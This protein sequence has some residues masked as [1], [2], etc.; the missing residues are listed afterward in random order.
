MTALVGTRDLVRFVLRRDRVRLPVWVLAIVGLT[1]FSATAVAGTYNTPREITSYA[2][3]MGNSPATVAMAGPPVA[4]DQIGGILVYETSM[5]ALLGVA[6]M[7][8][9]TV[10][11]HTRTEEEAGRTELL[12]STVV[13]RHAGV[14]AAFAVAAVASLVVGAG[15]T[16]SMLSVEMAPGPATLYGAAVVAMGVVFAGVAAVAAQLMTHGRGASG[17]ALAVLGVAFMLRA[18]GD[19]DESFLSWLS[20]MGWSQQVRV[21]EADRWWP[22]L[23]S[24]VFTLALLVVT[25]VLAAHR[26]T[27]SGVFAARPGP[28]R[29]GRLLS[30]P[31]GLAWRLQRSVVLAWAVGL[32]ALGAMFGSVTEELQNMVDDN[33]TLRQYFEQSGGDITDAFF[34]TALLFMGLGGAGF[35]VGSAL[36]LRSEETAGRL[37][38][39]LAT[40][41]SRPRAMFSTLAV[42]LVGSI[43]VVLSGGVGLGIA[44]AQFGGTTQ[45][46]VEVTMLALVQLPAVLVLVGVAVLLCGWLPRWT[47]VAWAGLAVAFVVGWLGPLLK[48]P[49]W[50]LGLSPFEHLP[51][52]PL[53]DLAT[54]PVV[55]LSVLALVLVAAGTLGFRRRDLTT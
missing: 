6:L 40:G 39:V 20:P 1:Y 24:S 46:A 55:L 52:V 27:G 34:A 19:V 33:P 44:Y 42:T 37:E 50:A 41:V 8:M 10:V 7:A 25:A 49:G 28:P 17:L 53:E 23:L 38:P 26:D 11:R 36:R 43:A 2:T 15:V 13:G 14:A 12:V 3:N 47:A 48:L 35:A 31:L 16:A 4:L 54:T 45:E 18:V 32:F 51:Q 21:L 22:L 9:F 29:A 5:T 30:S